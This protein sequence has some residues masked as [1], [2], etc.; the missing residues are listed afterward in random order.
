MTVWNETTVEAMVSWL[1]T[2]LSSAKVARKLGPHF[3]RN[4]IIGK[5]KRIGKRLNP[6]KGGRDHMAQTVKPLTKQHIRHK[7]MAI[8]P[9]KANF[10]AANATLALRD[11]QCRWPIGEP[12]SA[13][14]H[15]CDCVNVPGSPY[16]G[17]HSR[18]SIEPNNNWM[19]RK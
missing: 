7:V 5:A 16:C 17:E 9:K 18:K 2:G 14:F 15:F 19:K 6:I 8:T 10:A 12:E 3:T 11:D 1:D 4:M 13:E